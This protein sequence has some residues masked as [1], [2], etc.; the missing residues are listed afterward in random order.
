MKHQINYPL[1]TEQRN[2]LLKLFMTEYL[3]SPKQYEALDG[4][5]NLLDAILDEAQEETELY[6]LKTFQE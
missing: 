1:L 6:N 2:E 3:L 4:V 5:I